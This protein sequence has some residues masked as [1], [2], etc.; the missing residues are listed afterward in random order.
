MRPYTV[1]RFHRDHPV[2][3]ADEITHINALLD[4]HTRRRAPPTLTSM[5]SGA[6]TALLILLLLVFL[7]RGDICCAWPNTTV[8]ATTHALIITVPEP[9]RTS[10]P[11]YSV[12]AKLPPWASSSLNSAGVLWKLGAYVPWRTYRDLMQG[13]VGAALN[14][15][16]LMAGLMAVATCAHYVLTAGG[17][18]VQ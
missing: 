11:S 1:N 7:L 16:R 15:W 6:A 5:V 4:E 10:S 12:T 14:I 8:P 13:G 17:G 9:Q 18:G 2:K 3:W